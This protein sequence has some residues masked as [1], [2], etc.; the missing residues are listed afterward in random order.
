M[1]AADRTHPVVCFHMLVVSWIASR[2][3]RAVLSAGALWLGV[4]VAVDAQE[5]KTAGDSVLALE[6]VA[7]VGPCQAVE[8]D[9][10]RLYATGRGLF[11]VLDI[12]KPARPRLL[13]TLKGL[14]NTR[15]I[16][17]REKTAFV[18]ARQD[19]LW[20]LDVSDAAKPAIISHYDTV[21]MATGIW[22]SGEVAY[23]ATRQYGVEIID[24]SD[25]R[26]PRHLGMLK[27]GEAQ[28]CWAR[29]GMLYI[30][31]WAPKKLVVADV[32]DP[33]MPKI[34]G[35]ADLD[36]YGDGGCLRGEVCFAATGH[37]SRAADQDAGHGRGHGLEIFDVNRPDAPVLLSR[38][39]FP[40][41][42]Q[43]SNDMWS[44]RVSGDHCV[45]ADTW[46]GLFVVN[47]RNLKEPE[48]VARALLP[49]RPQGDVADPVGGIALGDGVIYAAGVFNGLYVVKAPGLAATV[50]RE[51]DA[52][53]PVP[54]AATEP[55]PPPDFIA[56]RPDGQVRSVT[57]AGDVAWTACGK[58]G[59]QAIRLGDAPAALSATLGK[60]DV[61]HL[62]VAG[63]RLYAA[64]N[65]AGLGIYRIGPSMELKEVGRL[66]MPGRSV[67]QVV[68]PP[69][70]RFALFH[71]GGAEAFV[72]DVGDP[73][74][75]KVALRDA[76]VGLFYGDQLVPEMLGGRFLV[77]F[78][79]RSGPAWYDVGG[80]TP[81]YRG[82]TPDENLF[83]FTD[84]ACALDGRL[85]IVQR[86]KLHALEPGETRNVRQLPAFGIEGRPLRGRPT[87]DGRRL[88]L[89]RRTDRRVEVLDIADLKAPRLLR[90]YELPGHPGACAFWNG[91]LVVPAAYAGLLIERESR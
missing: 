74:A 44:A 89:S 36:G 67:K 59:I 23:V 57:V 38:V 43:I 8:T 52:G 40:E 24:V 64:E 5:P 61:N 3:A 42:Y 37:H 6:K 63:D 20:L 2:R 66:A 21:E 65:A 79:Q 62:A 26:R 70:G 25:L 46:N 13:G 71:C 14:G 75:P 41:N 17:V 48:I 39:K 1:S 12:S 51:A 33:R 47:V 78:W 9:G 11:H 53:T 35:S 55:P 85:L 29:A 18:T 58:A 91:R 28:S 77:A 34:V 90:E 54:D 69:P 81:A 49:K 76:Q 31:D 27:T 45:V 73:A 16:F 86:G 68:C 50:V 32:R 7:G 87:T 83:S 60:G 10:G 80:T 4:S 30:G 19:G 15:Q 56:Y 72:A 88:A 82:N 22:V 84:G